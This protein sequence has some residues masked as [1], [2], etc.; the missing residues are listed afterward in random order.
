MD[1][2][3]LCYGVYRKAIQPEMGLTMPYLTFLYISFAILF[4]SS[5]ISSDMTIMKSKQP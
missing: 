1:F 4:G 2:S 5:D 3:G